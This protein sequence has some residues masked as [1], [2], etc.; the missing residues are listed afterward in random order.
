MERLPT[1]AELKHHRLAGVRATCWR[2]NRS[3]RYLGTETGA[4]TCAACT[5]LGASRSPFVSREALDK[6]HG[7]ARK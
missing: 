3:F 1:A 6:D 5:P 2:C 7:R 4:V